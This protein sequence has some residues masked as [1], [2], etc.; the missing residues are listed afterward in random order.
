MGDYNNY[1]A[2]RLG[3]EFEQNYYSRR[4]RDYYLQLL[5]TYYS[6]TQDERR[7]DSV[8]NLLITQRDV[9]F[10]GQGNIYDMLDTVRKHQVVM[11]NEAHHV[12]RHR[13][14]LGTLLDSLY[15]AGFRYLALEAFSNDSLLTEL[16]YP[17]MANGFYLRDPTFASLVRKAYRTGYKVVGYDFYGDEREKREAEKLY[18]KT[19]KVDTAAKVLVLAGYA[20]ITRRAMAGEFEKLSGVRPLTI[21]QTNPYAYHHVGKEALC[22][23]AFF[24]RY[25]PADSVKS[26]N[27]DF[28]LYNT[29]TVRNNCFSSSGAQVVSIV[30]PDSL[31]RQRCTIA[32]VYEATELRSF[33]RSAKQHPERKPIPVAVRSVEGNSAAAT[34]NLCSN[35][36][37]IVFLDDYGQILAEEFINVE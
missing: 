33:K 25:N 7:A 30:A 22:D 28:L 36:Y 26:Y 19:L 24:I 32:C 29:L 1:M 8:W 10:E 2:V 12:S 5:A 6:F 21:D 11:F 37:A 31:L 3:K 14:L 18:R 4:D 17:T 35:E 34:V 16:G 27:V 9:L 15:A 13:Y 20:H 23:T